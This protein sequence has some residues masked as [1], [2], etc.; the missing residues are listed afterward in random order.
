MCFTQSHTSSLDT[1]HKHFE[2]VKYNQ[3]QTALA[4]DAIENMRVEL[5]PH[6]FLFSSK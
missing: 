5:V 6:V 2:S 4:G 1:P 3:S